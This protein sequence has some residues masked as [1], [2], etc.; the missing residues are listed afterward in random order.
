MRKENSDH[1]IVMPS[2]PNFIM[3]FE[4]TKVKDNTFWSVK[5]SIGIIMSTTGN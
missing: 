2:L 1:I 4:T 3:R 5:Q